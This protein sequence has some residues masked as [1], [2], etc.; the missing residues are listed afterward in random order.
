MTP[1][2]GTSVLSSTSLPV[3]EGPADLVLG[4][5]D[6]DSLSDVNQEEYGRDYSMGPILAAMLDEWDKGDKL[7][8][9]GSSTASVHKKRSR[10]KP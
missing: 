6:E 2:T 5:S 10:R 7:L 8:K 4:D 9:E 3:R 1:S